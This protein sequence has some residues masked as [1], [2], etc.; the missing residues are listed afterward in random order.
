M[1]GIESTALARIVKID[2]W[3]VTMD[4]D[5]PRIMDE[6]LG[7][8]LGFARTRKIRELIERLLRDGKLND[9]HCRPT[10]GRQSTGNG[11]TR[12][13]VVDAYWLTKKQALKVIAKSETA[14]ADA[15][16]DVVID[17][18]D[19]VMRGQLVA[20]AQQVPVPVLSTSP[21][22]GDSRIHRAEIASWCRLAAHSNGVSVHRIHGELRRQFRVP[23]VYLI[24]LVLHP[25][26]RE[27]VEALALRRL[28]LPPAKS[29]RH[30]TAVPAPP[31]AVL[32][33]P[34]PPRTA[35]ETA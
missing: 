3:S 35:L 24:P 29:S 14:I 21:L 26:A 13:Y 23:S 9:I 15:I 31:Q 12:E 19:A 6:E 34:A 17:V 30:L 2:G 25:Q 18:F 7:K 27:L 32:P 11:G 4:D 22:V 28:L 16:L 10:V 33:F 1:N 8:R 5:E 20:A